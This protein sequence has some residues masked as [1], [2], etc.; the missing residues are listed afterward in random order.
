MAY[1]NYAPANGFIVAKDGNGD[2]STIATALT[3]ASSGTTIFIRPGTYTENLT[4]KA[5][6]NLTGWS[7][8]SSLNQAG[9]IIISGKATLTTAGTVTISDIQLQTN[10]DFLL[11]VTGTVASVVNLFNCNLNCTNNTGIS[12]TSSSASSK[13]LIYNCTGDLGTTGI[14]LFAS[15]SAGTLFFR[16][17]Y[18]TNSGASTTASTVTTGVLNFYGSDFD[19]PITI[20]SNGGCAGYHSILNTQSINTTSFTAGGSSATNGLTYCQIASGTASA[21]SA[22]GTFALYDCNINSSNT[23]AL[24]GSGTIIQSGCSFF[25]TSHQCNATNSGSGAAWGLTQGTAPAAGC[26]GEQIS[27]VVTGVSVSSGVITNITSISLTAGI[28]DVACLVYGASSAQFLD[29]LIG[30]IS[31]VNNTLPGNYADQ[32]NIQQP[33]TSLTSSLS[34]AVPA[35]RVVLSSTTTYYVNGYAGFTGGTCT[36]NGRISGTRVG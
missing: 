24:T 17:T 1:R 23:N 6:V 33:G 36:L 13:I 7:C 29:N 9:T 28:W 12:H 20:S 16:N 15:T 14:K 25:G 3:A 2:F 22:S 30:G 10:S 34:I 5:G 11:A 21:V 4:L 31:T 27:S 32:K 8:D 18:I 26:I 19:F 35:Y